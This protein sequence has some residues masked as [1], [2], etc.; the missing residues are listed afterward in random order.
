MLGIWAWYSICKMIQNAK[1]IKLVSKKDIEYMTRSKQ[2]SKPE[3][4]VV[5]NE[6]I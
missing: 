1:N 6:N 5:E 3:K 2:V 4:P